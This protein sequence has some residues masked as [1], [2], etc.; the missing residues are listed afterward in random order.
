MFVDADQLIHDATDGALL[1]IDEVLALVGI[2]HQEAEERVG[3]I[4]CLLDGADESCIG[5]P[6]LPR[7]RPTA[8]GL[9]IKY[10]KAE[11]G[12]GVLGA[13]TL[14]VPWELLGLPTS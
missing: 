10:G 14:V 11:A 6:R 8:A 1:A 4:G 12:A 7:G 9:V 3:R 13:R 5:R 2:E